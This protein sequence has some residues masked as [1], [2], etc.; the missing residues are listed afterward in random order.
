[1]KFNIL[2]APMLGALFLGLCGAAAVADPAR[3]A[4]SEAYIRAMPP[5]APVAGGF[6]TIRN[7]GAEGDRLV[8]VR[9]PRAGEVQIHEM[10]MNGSVMKMR[11]LPDGLPIPA[12]ETVVLKPG[13]FHL[14]FMQIPAP[15]AEGQTVEATLVFEKAGEVALPFEVRAMRPAPADHG[16]DTGHSG[17]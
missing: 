17:H 10:T 15:F 11:E 5:K 8:S 2:A 16:H 12:G 3:P 6:L 7:D 13:G 4:V 14:M 9:S 1:M